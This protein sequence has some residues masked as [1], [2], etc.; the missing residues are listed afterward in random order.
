VPAPSA[1]GSDG[2]YNRF[3]VSPDGRI[4]IDYSLTEGR[5]SHWIETP[6]V[7]DLVS[8]E[9]LFVL[10]EG[11]DAAATWIDGHNFTLWVRRYPDG[12]Y[13]LK[14]HCDVDEGTIRLGDDDTTQ[15]LS[16]AKSAIETHFARLGANVPRTAEP[17]RYRKPTQVWEVLLGLLLALAFVALIAAFSYWQTQGR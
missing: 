2:S 14:V 13:S 7:Y 10:A 3:V 1:S 4:R 9:V 6:A 12:G 16:G 5:M 15:P 11:Y 8:G 17:R